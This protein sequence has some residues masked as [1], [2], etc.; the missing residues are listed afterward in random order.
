MASRGP[1]QE[2]I[3]AIWADAYRVVT[4]ERVARTRLREERCKEAARANRRAFW[5]RLFRGA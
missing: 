1:T 3:D 4:E 2:E 5:A